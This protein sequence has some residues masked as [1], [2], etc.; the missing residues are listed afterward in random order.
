MLGP[1]N[2]A[3]TWFLAVAQQA[4]ELA[5]LARGPA[6]EADRPPRRLRLVP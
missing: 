1:E 6:D 5:L 3:Q 2:Y 4:E